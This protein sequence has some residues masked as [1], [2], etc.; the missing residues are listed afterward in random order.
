MT[1]ALVVVTGLA[2]LVTGCASS[3]SL[4][5]VQQDL[6][7]L[8]TDVTGL[9]RSHEIALREL[10]RTAGEIR[11]ID[12]RNAELEGALREQSA[13]A[14]RLRARLDAA[15]VELREAKAHLA[16]QD[17]SV[18]PLV[19]A[20][21]TPAPQ[22]SP[23]RSGLRESDDARRVYDAAIATFRAREHGQAV[24]DFIDFIAQYPTHPLTANA[25]YWIGEAYYMQRDYRQALVEF[26]RVVDMAPSS[27]KAAD[28][29]LR[30][31]L[32]H[33]NL[34]EN[35]SAQHAWQRV[36][37]DYPASDSAGRA[38]ALLREHAARRF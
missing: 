37:R 25:Q 14:A 1:R 34:R 31:G 10:A 9:R 20:A 24:L 23:R 4:R 13:E 15:E 29:L 11:A 2:V 26:Q 22:A 35:S 6:A 5:Q 17:P 3:A 28:A 32:A 30:M 38:R 27:P 21:A 7:N 33:T 36:V 19:P 18:T 12:I 8:H 16:S